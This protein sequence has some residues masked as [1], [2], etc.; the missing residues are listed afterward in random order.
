MTTRSRSKAATETAAARFASYGV[1]KSIQIINEANEDVE[2]IHRMQK[3][4]I[5]KELLS[6]N[7]SK[8]TT[9]DEEEGKSLLL[10]FSDC[11]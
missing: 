9:R 4:K 2:L 11:F 7:D 1:M 5:N 6:T 8:N 3:M 10:G